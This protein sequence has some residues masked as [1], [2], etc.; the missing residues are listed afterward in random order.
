M[1][2][3]IDKLI[4]VGSPGVGVHVMRAAA[5]N[6]T[7]VVSAMAREPSPALRCHFLEGRA[8]GSERTQPEGW[9][10]A[11]CRPWHAPYTA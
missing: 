5:A 10:G 1:T 4:F 9:T 2:S 6:L 8:A 3:A 11:L 7:P